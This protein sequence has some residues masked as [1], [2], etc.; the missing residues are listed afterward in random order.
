MRLKHSGLLIK[1]SEL[2]WRRRSRIGGAQ[3]LQGL[4][5]HVKVFVLYPNKSYSRF[6]SRR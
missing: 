5:V 6:L 3:T 1:W 2:A 4:V